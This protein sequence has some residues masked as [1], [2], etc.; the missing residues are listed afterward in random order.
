MEREGNRGTRNGIREEEAGDREWGD[1]VMQP[2][3]GPVHL[4]YEVS[5]V[6]CNC[7]C[8]FLLHKSLNYYSPIHAYH[9]FPMLKLRYFLFGMCV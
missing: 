9:T 5:D 4:S 7:L 2:P 1:Q 3:K 6:M 8:W